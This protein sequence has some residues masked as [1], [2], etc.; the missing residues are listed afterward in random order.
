MELT[1]TWVINDFR[2]SGFKRVMKGLNYS[3]LWSK[4]EKEIYCI[5]IGL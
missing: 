2:D 5:Q 1:N 4:L 3:R